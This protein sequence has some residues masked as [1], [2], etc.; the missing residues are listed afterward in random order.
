MGGDAKTAKLLEQAGIAY[1]QGYF[2]GAPEIA[3]PVPAKS[4]G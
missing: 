2:F 1:T 4:A 3:K